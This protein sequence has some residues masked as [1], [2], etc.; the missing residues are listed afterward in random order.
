M[1]AAGAALG[2]RTIYYNSGQMHFESGH[3]IVSE[4][5]CKSDTRYCD[6]SPITNDDLS[7]Q[8]SLATWYSIVSAYGKRELTKYMDKFSALSGIASLLGGALKDRYVGGLWSNDMVEG[9]AWQSVDKPNTKQITEYVGPSWSWAGY[10]GVAAH[11]PWPIW[12]S[13]A[14]VISWQIELTNPDDYYGQLKS[15][16]IRVQGPL[17]ELLPSVIPVDDIERLKRAGINPSPHFYTK[18]ISEGESI[19]LCFDK[20]EMQASNPWR[21]KN[22]KMLVLG[23]HDYTQPVSQQGKE[24][25]DKGEEDV[26]EG[27]DTDKTE[28]KC[29]I[30]PGFSVALVSININK[31]IY[32]EDRIHIVKC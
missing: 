5:G 21:D 3:G 18:N 32:K 30:Q 22:I 10:Q 31:E 9:L 4:D 19:S 1:G 11:G 29:G 26:K 28:R 27:S 8:E 17:M 25:K 12:K 16:S 15:A 20:K 14:T 6:L 2:P 23:Y 13:I 24:V 7:P